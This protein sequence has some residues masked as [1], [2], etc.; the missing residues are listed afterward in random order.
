MLPSGL[1]LLESKDGKEY[2]EY[3]KNNAPC[4]LP[5]EGIVH[6]ELTVMPEDFLCFVYEEISGYYALV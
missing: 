4:H 3:S 1:L 6:P 2:H 5:I